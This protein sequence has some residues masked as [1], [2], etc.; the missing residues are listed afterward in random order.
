V[1]TNRVSL[2]EIR[3]AMELPA[4]RS[5]EPQR[6]FIPRPAPPVDEGAGFPPPR[7][8][9]A[10]RQPKAGAVLLLLYPKDGELH[11]AL[12]R[13]TDLVEDHKGQI[14]FPGGA[15]ESDDRS[16][17]ATALRE[18]REELGLED[19]TIELIGE[20]APVYIIASNYRVAPF[21]AFCRQQPV[22]HPDPI[23]VA[24]L[25][26]VPLSL[27]LQPDTVQEEDWELRGMTMRVP[28]FRYGP[29]KIWGATAQMLGQFVALL[30]EKGDR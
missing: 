4:A 17:A 16:L 18:A 30:T 8:P 2:D 3:R 15:W 11:L 20:L 23:E 26:E 12:T 1:N 19:Q 25:L 14:S 29:H 21:V 5:V 27:L 24:E 13:R 28:F 22:F 10:G 7:Q 9:E 6:R